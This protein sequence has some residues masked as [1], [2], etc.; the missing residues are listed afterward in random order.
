[1]TRGLS[2]RSGRVEGARARGRALHGARLRVGLRLPRHHRDGDGVREAR[3]VD[4]PTVDVVSRS[5]TEYEDPIK[6]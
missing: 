2:A 4:D 5:T 6:T 3:H 1:M